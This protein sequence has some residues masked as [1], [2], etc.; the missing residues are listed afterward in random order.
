M[1]KKFS[2]L[3]IAGILIGCTNI[4]D[5][6]G[7]KDGGPIREIGG[8][9]EIPGETK[10]VE[11]APVDDGKIVN[12]EANNE[13]IKEYLSI[14]KG[15]LKGSVKKVEDSVKND[16]TVGL[17]ETLIFPLDNERAINS[18]DRKSVV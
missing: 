4:D 9:P 8:E 11:N 7:K 10:V 3:L 17:G 13:N 6:V 18:V 12:K 5:L 1:L 15:N 2:I 14:V 16:Y